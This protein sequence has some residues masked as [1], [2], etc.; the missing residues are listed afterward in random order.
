[1]FFTRVLGNSG[2]AW[3][4]MSTFPVPGPAK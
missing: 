1:L 4:V 3:R 2:G